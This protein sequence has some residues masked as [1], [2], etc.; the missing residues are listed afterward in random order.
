MTVTNFDSAFTTLN[1]NLLQQ[2]TPIKTGFYIVKRNHP[3]FPLSKPTPLRT[4]QQKHPQHNLPIPCH[5]TMGVKGVALSPPP[6][7]VAFSAPEITAK[8][9]ATSAMSAQWIVADIF[10]TWFVLNW[11]LCGSKTT[12][13]VSAHVRGGKVPG[14]E[15]KGHTAD[16]DYNWWLCIVNKCGIICFVWLIIE[17]WD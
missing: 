2:F 1:F 7:F 5:S 16:K 3:H 8:P 10:T 9:T 15:V 11:S 12:V 4:P 17:R 14:A 13:K 6:C